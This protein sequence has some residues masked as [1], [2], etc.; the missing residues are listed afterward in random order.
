MFP[1]RLVLKEIRKISSD[2][3]SIRTK[4]R[5]SSGKTPLSKHSAKLPTCKRKMLKE[6]SVPKNEQQTKA[7]AK[8]IQGAEN[9]PQVGI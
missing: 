6:F 5:I 4:G 8:N 7:S 3:I 1:S 9:L 2:L